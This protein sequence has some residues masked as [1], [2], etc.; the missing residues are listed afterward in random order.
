MKHEV[1]SMNTKKKLS[2]SL[3][4]F[5]E[6][7]K[8]SKISVSEIVAD[9]KVN[10]K[11]FYY[12]FSD[13]YDLLKWTLEQETVEVLK[14]FGLLSNPEEALVFVADYVDSNLH[15]LNCAYDS[16][17][18]D[19]MKRFFFADFKG[20]I[21][22]A[23]ETCEEEQGRK[24]SDGLRKYLSE[25]YTE[26]LAGTLINYFR[27]KKSVNRDEMIKY[28]LLILRASIPHIISESEE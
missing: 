10:R 28:T 15:I 5:M 1:T 6:H 8:L 26:A 23:I 2:A 12:H 17:G 25:F 13:I 14:N 19:E 21:L 16:M 11:T 27:N 18:R 7:K 4:K 3:K 9:C 22:S 24:I 20:V